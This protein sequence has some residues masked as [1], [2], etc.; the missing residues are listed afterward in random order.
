MFSKIITVSIEGS[1]FFIKSVILP[2][3]G[4]SYEILSFQKLSEDFPKF[5]E[6]Y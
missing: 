6:K 2:N 5:K 3:Y 4:Q 1:D